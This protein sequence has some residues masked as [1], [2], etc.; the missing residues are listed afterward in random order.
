MKTFIEIGACD[1]GTLNGLADQGGWQGVIVEPVKKYLDRLERH[2]NVTY[3]NAAIDQA[4]GERELWLCSDDL[5]ERDRDYSGMSSFH[6][7]PAHTQSI[8]VKTL[9]YSQLLKQCGFTRVDYLKIDTEGHDYE[10]LKTVD[11]SAQVRPQLIKV[12]HKHCKLN[13][14][15][16]LLEENDYL[17]DVTEQ[18]VWAIAK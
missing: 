15:L 13:N 10:I 5:C 8:I 6:K 18:D 16:K 4:E 17:C 12:E 2:Q 11:F 14:I 1:F 7:W 3:L 9:T